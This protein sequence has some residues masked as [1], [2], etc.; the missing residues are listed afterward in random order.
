MVFLFP[1]CDWF[2]KGQVTQSAPA[3]YERTLP[4]EWFQRKATKKKKRGGGEV[5]HSIKKKK[6]LEKNGYFLL[7]VVLCVDDARLQYSINSQRMV[8]QTE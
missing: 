4:G 3:K 5:I 7:K 8:E 6:P 1:F 2:G